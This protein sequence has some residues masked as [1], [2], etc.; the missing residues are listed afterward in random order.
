MSSTQ[1][2]IDFWPSATDGLSPRLFY[3]EVTLYWLKA[4]LC[5]DAVWA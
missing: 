5:G 2:N 4:G 3:C 1:K